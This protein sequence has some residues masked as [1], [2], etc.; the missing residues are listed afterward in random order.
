MFSSIVRQ[1][2]RLSQSID[3]TESSLAAH[4]VS[5]GLDRG[6]EED[7][8]TLRQL[9]VNHVQSNELYQM[10]TGVSPDKLNEETELFRERGTFCGN[11]GDLVVRV[12]ADVLHV[13]IVVITSLASFPY[14]YTVIPRLRRNRLRTL[15][16]YTKAC[17]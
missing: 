14:D 9:F 11:L 15:R 16:C 6:E 4:L 5:L 2:K 8:Y 12:C 7:A 13:P 17:R 10:V 1:L 3:K